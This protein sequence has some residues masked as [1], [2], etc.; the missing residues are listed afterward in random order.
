LENQN[1]DIGKYLHPLP[2]CSINIMYWKIHPPRERGCHLREKCEKGE[3][4]KG[5]KYER[6]KVDRED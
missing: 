3:E 4:K 1:L 2:N 6:K 5:R